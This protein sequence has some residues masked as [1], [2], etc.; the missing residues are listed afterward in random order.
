MNSTY[1]DVFR[2]TVIGAA[3]GVHVAFGESQRHYQMYI[4]IFIAITV[5]IIC[6]CSLLTSRWMTHGVCGMY[7]HKMY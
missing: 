2:T 4:V 1:H 6:G 7:L 5:I 3:Q